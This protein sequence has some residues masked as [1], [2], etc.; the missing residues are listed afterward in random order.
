MGNADAGIFED[1]SW[2]TGK[3]QANLKAAIELFKRMLT[4]ED[5]NSNGFSYGDGDLPK[6]LPTIEKAFGELDAQVKALVEKQ[7]YPPE[8]KVSPSVKEGFAKAKKAKD[9]KADHPN[10][11]MH[12]ETQ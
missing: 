11:A 7:G 12:E 1:W 10:A 4:G 6:H 2:E 8:S 5:P 9:P 3:K